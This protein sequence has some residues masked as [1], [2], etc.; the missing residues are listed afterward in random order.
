MNT[1]RLLVENER[2]LSTGI[3]YCGAA[4]SHRIGLFLIGAALVLAIHAVR[5]CAGPLTTSVLVDPVFVRTARLKALHDRL[6]T[7]SAVAQEPFGIR[8]RGYPTTELD[9][10]PARQLV[11]VCSS[12]I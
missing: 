12:G 4:R 1:A 2:Q 11:R 3:S 7:A 5:V 6:A 10:V 9:G 8:A